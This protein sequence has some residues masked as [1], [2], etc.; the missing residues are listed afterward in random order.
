MLTVRVI[1]YHVSID[2][3]LTPEPFCLV[4]DLLEED[5]HPAELLARHTGGAGT[6]PKRR[7]I[8]VRTPRPRTSPFMPCWRISRSTVCLDTGGRPSAASA[9][10]SR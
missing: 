2:D 7:C 10:F 9:R 5:T 8:V 3:Q 6:G 4:T 1:E